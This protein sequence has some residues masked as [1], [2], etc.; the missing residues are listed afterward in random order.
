M[1]V[2]VYDY[3]INGKVKVWVLTLR[4]LLALICLGKLTLNKTPPPPIHSCISILGHANPYN[5]T[6]LLWQQYGANTL[7]VRNELINKFALST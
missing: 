6:E 7:Y 5:K 2:K 3:C 1:Q 4:Q